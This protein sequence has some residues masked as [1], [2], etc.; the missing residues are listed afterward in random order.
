[1]TR[2]EWLPRLRDIFGGRPTRWTENP[3]GDYNG[4]ERTLEVFNAEASDQLKLLRQFRAVRSDVET[5]TGG[6][7]IVLFHTTKETARLYADVV[8]R[9]LEERGL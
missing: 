7:V 9:D 1:M 6:P 2:A 5:T 3:V 4:R 8:A